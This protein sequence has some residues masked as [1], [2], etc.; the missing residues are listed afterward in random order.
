MKKIFF[1]LLLNMILVQL[2]LAQQTK[3][4]NFMKS[5]LECT[6]QDTIYYYVSSTQYVTVVYNEKGK[7][8][9]L[10]VFE[11]PSL[12]LDPMVM[13]PKKNEVIYCSIDKNGL[14][15]G[16]RIALTD[17]YLV[18]ISANESDR[19]MN[20]RYIFSR[21]SNYLSLVGEYH[22]GFPTKRTLAFRNN[23]KILFDTDNVASGEWL[24]EL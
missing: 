13:Q 24:K 1:T 12:S 10:K 23:G 5:P 7:V 2:S 17:G 22:N 19:L 15:N 21:K 3:V 8:H 6:L 4:N 14:M 18:S 20:W 16:M 9:D 11:D